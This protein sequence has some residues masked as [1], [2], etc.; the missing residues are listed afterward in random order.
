[1]DQPD[2]NNISGLLKLHLREHP[3]LSADS[4]QA[5]EDAMIDMVSSAHSQTLPTSCYSYVGV[6]G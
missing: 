4:S 2:P 3:F 6:P 1:M 5:L